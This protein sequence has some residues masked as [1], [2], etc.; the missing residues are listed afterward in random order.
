VKWGELLQHIIQELSNEDN[1]SLVSKILH[2]WASFILPVVDFVSSV[3]FY[4]VTPQFSGF[5]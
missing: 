3:L 5:R 1:A 4:K 2:F